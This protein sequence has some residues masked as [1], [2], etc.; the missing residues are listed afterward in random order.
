MSVVP[1]DPGPATP[2]MTAPD[3][4]AVRL[5]KWPKILPGMIKNAELDKNAQASGEIATFVL[6]AAE[7]AG[8]AQ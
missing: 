5:S 2:T 6:T 1:A 3:L 8:A 4:T 7:A